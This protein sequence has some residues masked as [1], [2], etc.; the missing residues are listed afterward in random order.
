VGSIGTNS[1]AHMH[2]WGEN[3]KKKWTDKVKDR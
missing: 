2:T 1:K 3:L